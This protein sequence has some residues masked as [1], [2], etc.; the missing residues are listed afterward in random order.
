MF[1]TSDPIRRR[2][3]DRWRRHEQRRNKL[4]RLNRI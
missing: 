4:E 2:D 3:E 1:G